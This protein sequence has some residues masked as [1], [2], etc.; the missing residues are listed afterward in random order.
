MKHLTGNVLSIFVM[1][2]ICVIGLVCW[3][4]LVLFGRAWLR[5]NETDL[6]REF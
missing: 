2:A 5:I 3:V 1:A 4:L 6:G